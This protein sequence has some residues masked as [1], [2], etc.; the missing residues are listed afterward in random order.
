MPDGIPS[1]EEQLERAHRL[2]V[3]AESLP[4]GVEHTIRFLSKRG[5]WFRISRNAP[6]TSCKEAANN[7]Q[8]LGHKGIFL[9]QEMKS[10][11]GGYTDGSGG[12]HYVA[13]HCRADR[14]L[15]QDLV[16]RALGGAEL[17]RLDE[18][19]LGKLGMAYGLVTPFEPWAGTGVQVTQIFDPDLTEPIGHP[20]T[21][22]TNAGDY[23]W[24]I[25]FRARDVAAY[26]AN[27]KIRPIAVIDPSERPR[28]LFATDPPV[29]GMISG[30]PI[31]TGALFLEF[32]AASVRK[33]LGRQKLVERE[34]M[35]WEEL[36]PVVEE[37]CQR[38]DILT[39]PC[40]TT[41]YF[42]PKIR[43]ICD[44]HGVVF[45][46]MP[47]VVGERLRAEKISNVAIV[48]IPVVA[49]VSK[50]WSPYRE[51]LAGIDVEIAS[52]Y[53]LDR[54]TELAYEVKNSGASQQTLNKLRNTLRD[55]G[56]QSD[57]VIIALTELSQLVELQTKPGQKL[58][59]DPLGMYAD[60][61][62]NLW[63]SPTPALRQAMEQR[64]DALSQPSAQ[65]SAA[66]NGIV[67]RQ[68]RYDRFGVLP[69]ARV[70]ARPVH[71]IYAGGVY[72][73]PEPDQSPRLLNWDEVRDRMPLLNDV[74]GGIAELDV[75][76]APIDGWNIGPGHCAQIAKA[77]ASTWDETAGTVVVTGSTTAAYV[78]AMLSYMWR[79]SQT[80]HIVSGG[81][82]G[83]AAARA[84]P[85]VLAEVA[86]RNILGAVSFVARHE[87]FRMF[88]P[89]VYLMSGRELIVGTRVL[90]SGPN[91]EALHDARD[92]PVARFENYRWE[93]KHT[94]PRTR[95]R[96]FLDTRF[97]EQVGALTVLGHTAPEQL[98][99]H[100][101]G[102]EA[103]VLLI[104]GP[105][106]L[107][108]NGAVSL[109]A[110]EIVNNGTNVAVVSAS[111]G[112]IDLSRTP[113][114]RAQPQRRRLGIRADTG[115]RDRESSEG[116][117]R[118]RGSRSTVLSRVR[119]A[120]MGRHLSESPEPGPCCR[121]GA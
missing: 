25:E 109:A 82:E 32:L 63:I 84:E 92:S 85:H 104:D 67:E 61:V 1:L 15:D 48:G 95:S 49:D 54:I 88:I 40:N 52:P 45:V 23:T 46:S 106:M 118:S 55:G 21:V 44:S 58:L 69:G 7:R 13:L 111:G 35:I 22:M 89:G 80:P 77:I 83:M 14:M 11:F 2:L 65:E 117:R 102:L 110:P 71:L 6:A 27:S 107:D 115:C 78:S 116:R 94:L 34:A 9:F 37:L 87:N 31:D 28:P 56:V 50:K 99:R 42:T 33:A 16:R 98:V 90:E 47:E 26:V 24:G 120:A 10:F 68:G 62:A 66:D 72:D 51:P 70:K 19:E 12:R 39:V 113:E 38:V 29:I 91:Y 60:A 108:A 30:N 3:G 81:I 41:P 59:I 93:S 76:D 20:P 57:A 74:P 79:N 114:G 112:R 101:A 8:R 43:E 119:T 17:E 4:P 53:L 96:A 105:E 64:R 97:R 36:A 18:D 75:F 5:V 86:E 100:S 103:V 73:T 121:A